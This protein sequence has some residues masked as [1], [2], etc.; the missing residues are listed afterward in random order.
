MLQGISYRNATNGNL[1]NIF[2]MNV[3]NIDPSTKKFILQQL[4]KTEK[5][6]LESAWQLPSKINPALFKAFGATG[7]RALTTH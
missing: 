3:P 2:Q 5:N 7:R 4:L 1:L 6:K